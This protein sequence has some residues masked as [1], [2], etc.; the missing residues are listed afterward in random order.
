MRYSLLAGLI[1]LILGQTTCRSSSEKRAPAIGE[2]YAGPAALALRKDIPPQSPVTA[3]VPHGERLDILQHRR[4]FFKVRTV[5]GKEGWIEDHLL[6]SS[7]EIA[8]LKEVERRA[9]T[10]PTQGLASTYELLNVHTEPNRLSP[11]FLQIAA[12]EKVDVVAHVVS[13]RTPPARKP[14]LPPKPKQPK[15]AHKS[16]ETRYPPP[17]PP[18]PPPVPANWLALS[19]TPPEVA[20]SIAAAKAESPAP[21]DDWSLVRNAKGD[22]GWVLTHRIYMAIPDDVAQYAEGHRITSYFPLRDVRDGDQVKH[23]WL[24]TTIGGGDH[25]YDFDSYR[26]FTW[27]LR[28]HRYE[29]AFIQRNVEGY[30]PVLLRPVEW[31]AGSKARTPSD[32]AK[33]PGFSVC[34]ED[35]HGVRMRRSYALIDTVVRSAGQQ[36]CEAPANILQTDGAPAPGP[37]SLAPNPAAGSRSLFARLKA[38]AKKLFSR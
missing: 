21:T 30:F 13:P 28:R 19:K 5:G 7:G 32:T 24:W 22:S 29:T 25:N 3:T 11:S 17:P 37:Q 1:V 8:S 18:P 9:R 20:Q 35:A 33:Y 38:F 10:L 2:A 23:V 16:P 26:V 34:V 14:L 36:P 15:V 27:S 12:G 4:R 31:S 6:L